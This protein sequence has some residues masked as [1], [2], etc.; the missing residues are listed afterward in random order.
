[1]VMP[2]FRGYRKI[3]LTM[4]VELGKLEI[5]TTLLV[6]TI[7]HKPEFHLDHGNKGIC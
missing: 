6:I 1:M 4:S 2:N 3:N 5:L 7:F